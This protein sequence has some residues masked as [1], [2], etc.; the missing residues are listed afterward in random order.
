MRLAPE[1]E[2]VE[3]AVAGA[4]SAVDE[5]AEDD[6][7]R[8]TV[9][10]QQLAELLKIRNSRPA[11]ERNAGATKD[12]VLAEVR[13]GDQQRRTGRPDHRARRMKEHALAPQLDRTSGEALSHGA[14]DAHM[15]QHAPWQSY[16]TRP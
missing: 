1:P 11:R 10:C 8:A 2:G 5:V 12:V 6:Q 9:R 7:P 3:E 15:R 13:V 4:G 16:R 14:C